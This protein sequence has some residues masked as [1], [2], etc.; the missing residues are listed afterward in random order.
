MKEYN[1]KKD[2]MIESDLQRVYNS[3]IC[4]RDSKVYSNK[5]FVNIDFGSLGGFHWTCFIMKDKKS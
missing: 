2:T 1:L 3:P 4:P 5:D